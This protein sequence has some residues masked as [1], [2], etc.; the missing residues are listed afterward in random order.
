MPLEA[1]VEIEQ[2]GTSWWAKVSARDLGKDLSWKSTEIRVGNYSSLFDG[3][4]EFLDS[5][6]PRPDE[7]APAQKGRK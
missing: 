2:L 1:Q 6:V 3:V 5:I 7:P 4:V